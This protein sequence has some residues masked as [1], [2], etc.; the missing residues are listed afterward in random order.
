MC[1]AASKEGVVELH[2]TTLPAEYHGLT[3]TNRADAK[4]LRVLSI[5]SEKEMI[6]NGVVYDVSGFIKRHPGGS[7]IKFQLGTDAS[8]AF[9]AFHMRSA[10]ANKMLRSLPSREVA[11]ADAADDALSRDFE[12]LRSELLAEGYF[13]PNPK[14]VVYRFIEVLVLYYAGFSLIWSGWWWAGCLVAGVAQG[15]CG[16]LMHELSLI[17]I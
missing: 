11:S 10:K 17:H 12:A 2:P 3:N 5:D 8:D 9:R 7:V 4:D 1:K 14:H 13:E 15:R 16:W 6:I